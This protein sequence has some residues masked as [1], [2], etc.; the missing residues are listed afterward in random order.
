MIDAH[1]HLT[2]VEPNPVSAAARNAAVVYLSAANARKTLE[3]GVTTV[4]DLGA[5]NY[6]DLAMRDLDQQGTHAWPAHVRSG[7]GVQVQRGGTVT[8]GTATGSRR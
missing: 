6:A 2:Y 3:T 5:Q 8:P 1:T 4:R 7:Y